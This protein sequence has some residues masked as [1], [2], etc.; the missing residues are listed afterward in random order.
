MPLKVNVK[1][2]NL[3]D[4]IEFPC[5]LKR[6]VK[7]SNLIVF[8]K[9][10][11]SNETFLGFVIKESVGYPLGYMSNVWNLDE[12]ELFKGTIELTQS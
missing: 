12:F 10:S 8:A 7:D 11:D 2:K 6:K 1:E 9:H 4:K 5:L 3:N